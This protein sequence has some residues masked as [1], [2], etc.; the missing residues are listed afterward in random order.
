MARRRPFRV[1][2]LLT[3][4]EEFYEV[5]LGPRPGETI[6]SVFDRGIKVVRKDLRQRPKGTLIPTTR[7]V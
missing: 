2:V 6:E 1:I 4:G 5:N 7:G 3:D